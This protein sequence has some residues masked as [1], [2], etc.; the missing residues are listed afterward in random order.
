VLVYESD[1]TFTA[2][3]MISKTKEGKTKTGKEVR[4]EGGVWC[5]HRNDD[6]AQTTMITMT[7]KKR[8]AT[9]NG[10]EFSNPEPPR[11][12]AMKEGGRG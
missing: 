12:I 3:A 10:I 7:V 1:V 5:P 9:A 2:D 4:G 11:R 6:N 8:M